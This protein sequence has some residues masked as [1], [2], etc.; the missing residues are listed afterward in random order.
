[1]KMTSAI[2]Y[3]AKGMYVISA[4]SYCPSV[5]YIRM[6][7]LIVFCIAICSLC[8]A[9]SI[10]YSNMSMMFVYYTDRQW[11][12]PDTGGANIPALN[13]LISPLNMAFRLVSY[14]CLILCHII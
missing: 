5:D 2:L 1:V 3:C 12:M 13:D 8:L 4:T 7:A 10:D 6:L 9:V 14:H 11:W